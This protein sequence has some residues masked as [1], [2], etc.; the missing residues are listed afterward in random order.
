MLLCKLI[1]GVS[2][3]ILLVKIAKNKNQNKK[4]I[5]EFYFELC[6]LIE[7]FYNEMLYRKT[8]LKDFLLSYNKSEFLNEIIDSYLSGKLD[9]SC[10]KNK[11]NN[12]EA[13]FILSLFNEL[14][15]SNS[16]SQ[17]NVVEFYKEKF[18]KIYVEKF[19]E[20]KKHSK[21]YVKIAFSVG[22][23]FLIMVI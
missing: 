10:F 19:N 14:G 17:K 9:V 20:Y 13:N 11:L 6:S 22:L 1:L 18:N 23:M 16:E 3:I 21:L 8:P 12:D 4:E 2:V 5:V 15:K 7:G